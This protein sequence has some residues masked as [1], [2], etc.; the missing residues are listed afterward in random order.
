[1]SLEEN[2][3]KSFAEVRKDILEIKNQV[4]KL[5]EA[6]ERLEAGISKKSK[7]AKKPAKK[8]SRKKK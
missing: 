2:L 6:Q 5:A 7:P 1:M 8:S 4:L 3:R